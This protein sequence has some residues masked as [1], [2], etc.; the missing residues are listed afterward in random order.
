MHNLLQAIEWSNQK[1]VGPGLRVYGQAT[2][3]MY[4]TKN[5]GNTITGKGRADG[6]KKKL[7]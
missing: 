7:N 2:P 3:L 1:F 5:S 6:N 4:Y